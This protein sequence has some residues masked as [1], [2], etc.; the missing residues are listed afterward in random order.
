VIPDERTPS[1]IRLTFIGGGSGGH[2]F[3]AIAVAHA[4]LQQTDAA[5]FQFLCSH[6]PVDAK[7]L[8][9]TGLGTDRVLIEPYVSPARNTNLL[10]RLMMVPNLVGAIRVARESLKKF[11]PH[12]VVGVGALASVPGVIAASRLR[13]PI[14]LME[15]NTI[16]G[17][18]TQLLAPRSQLILAGLPFQESHARKWPCPV[19]V[20]G[21]PVRTEISSLY[22]VAATTPPARD[23]L[24]ILGGSQ[25]SSTVN[26]LMLEALADE[27]CVPSDWQIIHQTGESE[28]NQVA[29]EYARRGRTA[30]VL[31]FLPNLPELL[32]QA[33][34]VVSRAGAGTLQELSCAGLPSILIP[35]SDAA[36]QHQLENARLFA[37]HGAAALV[38]ETDEDA[39]QQ[40]RVLLN[41]L[42]QSP[43][44][45][46]RFRAG[47]RQFAKPDAAELT[48]KQILQRCRQS[49]R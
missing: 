39:G 26:R 9:A 46:G 35:Y 40:L 30:T 22:S 34:L 28:V 48:A 42:I 1:E 16:P 25:G 41:S 32:G 29:A 14:V 21:T 44:L 49:Q 24:L 37:D 3:P 18:A 4:V 47:I 15:Q 43:Q 19:Q 17:K 36:A 2:L 33:T 31:S 13:L 7:V 45:R 38:D 5:R 10:E 6:R 12:L 27:H 8:A 23:R 20:T 11:Q